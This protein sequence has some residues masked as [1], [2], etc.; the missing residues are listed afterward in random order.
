VTLDRPTESGIRSNLRLDIT[1]ALLGM[2]FC[3]AWPTS[4]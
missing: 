1:A 4:L 3:I 2:E